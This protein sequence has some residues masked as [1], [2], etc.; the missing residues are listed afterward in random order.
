MANALMAGFNR[1]V[2]RVLPTRSRDAVAWS[3]DGTRLAPSSN[4]NTARIW[5]V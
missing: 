1:I 3:P 2:H 5:A 4:D